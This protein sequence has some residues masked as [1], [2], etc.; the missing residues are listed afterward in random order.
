MSMTAKQ[1]MIGAITLFDASNRVGVITLKSEK[2]LTDIPDDITFFLE[3]KDTRLFH[4]G[5]LV[6]F[7][8]I[9][10]EGRWQAREIEVL[11]AK[12]F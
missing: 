9:Q 7:I 6:Q 11:S 4:E 12:A 5:Q 8:I 10:E 2:S 3:E 1:A